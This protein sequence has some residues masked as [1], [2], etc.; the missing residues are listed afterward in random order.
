MVEL[1]NALETFFQSPSW[2][3]RLNEY[4][5]GNIHNAGVGHQASILMEISL[6]IN[7]LYRGMK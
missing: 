6:E 1:M 5:N 7:E 3:S 2:K 4:D